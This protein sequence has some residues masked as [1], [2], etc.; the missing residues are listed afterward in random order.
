MKNRTLMMIPG[1]IE[2]E[3]AVLGALGAPTASHVAPDFIE[4]FGQ[5]IERMREVWKSPSGQ[6]FIIA[7]SGTLAMEIPAANLVEPGDHALVISSG[8]FGERYAEILKRY[9]A[10]VTALH[11]PLGDITD[12]DKIETEIKK[13]SYKLMTFTHVDTSTAVRVDPKPIGQLGQKYNVLTILDGVCSVGGEELRQEEWGI[14]VALTASQKAIG[15]PT[16][17]A[18]VVAGP[19]AIAARRKTENTRH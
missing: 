17:L 11:A 19:Q 16:G 14:D 18:L 13:G 4:V 1:P 10:E 2:F 6:P 3:P 7:G 5:A 12:P 8:Y 9:G 15:V